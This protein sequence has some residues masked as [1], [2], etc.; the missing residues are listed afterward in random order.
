LASAVLAWAVS[1]MSADPTSKCRLGTIVGELSLFHLLFP[2]PDVRPRENN[3]PVRGDDSL[4]QILNVVLELKV[5]TFRVDL[6]NEDRSQV[7]AAPRSL[8]QRLIPLQ[9]QGRAGLGVQRKYARLGESRARIEEQAGGPAQLRRLGHG[10][11]QVVTVGPDAG[12]A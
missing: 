5:R 3:G 11:V 7:R 10:R 9:S 1:P 8:Q 6:G 4:Y 2:R 12:D